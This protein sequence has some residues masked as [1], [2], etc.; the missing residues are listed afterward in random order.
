MVV[1]FFRHKVKDYEAWKAVFDN[2]NDFRKA[3]GEI[4]HRVFHAIEDPNDIGLMF[5]W[6]S[7]E[8]AHQFMSSPELKAKMIEAGVVGE[9]IFDFL[10]EY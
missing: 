3:G 1:V 6:E 7:L 5:E 2:A 8:K 9:P 4:S 10:K